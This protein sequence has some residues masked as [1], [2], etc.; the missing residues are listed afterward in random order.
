MPTILIRRIS[1]YLG[2]DV[3]LGVFASTSEAE[4]QR[5]IYFAM[6]TEKPASDPWREQ[7]YKTDGLQMADL[8]ILNIQG[9]QVSSGAA[10]FVISSDSQGFG[11]MARRFIS[12]HNEQAVALRQ[13]AK[14]EEADDDSF[15][16]FYRVQ[17]VRVGEL[18]PDDPDLPPAWY[19]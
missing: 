4:Q 19:E 16:T 7:P 13:A 3:L 6:R 8:V 1:A 12:V 9:S 17:G 10:A 18:L 15:P 14:F 11:Q 2:A 5:D